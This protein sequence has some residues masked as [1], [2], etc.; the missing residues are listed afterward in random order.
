MLTTPPIHGAKSPHKRTDIP[1]S[2]EKDLFTFLRTPEVV[3]LE[4]G[5]VDVVLV[6]ATPEV[7]EIE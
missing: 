7:G 6:L 3:V 1:P 2:A 5:A 4:R